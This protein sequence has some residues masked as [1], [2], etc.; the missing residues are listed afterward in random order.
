MSKTIYN[1]V[2]LSARTISYLETAL[3]SSSVM[4]PCTEDQLIDG[5]MDV[6]SDHPLHNINEQDDL[7][8]HFNISDITQDTLKWAEKEVS[9]FF[10]M[11]EEMNLY[12]ETLEYADDECIS[13]DLWLTQNNHGAGFWDGDYGNSLGNTLTALCEQHFKEVTLIITEDGKI[14]RC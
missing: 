9:K 4:L 3:W 13:H 7:D 11:L 1:N 12:E 2:E 8:N 5:C 14:E 6:E 10:K